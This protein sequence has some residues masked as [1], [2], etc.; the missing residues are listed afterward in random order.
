M[1]CGL[2]ASTSYMYLQAYP[3]VC[4]ALSYVLCRVEDPKLILPC[5]YVESSIVLSDVL[6]KLIA[7]SGTVFGTC[8][9]Y[10]LAFQKL[11]DLP[12]KCRGHYLANVEGIYLAS[13]CWV[14]P[15]IWR[16]SCLAYVDGLALQVWRVPPFLMF[17]IL[18]CEWWRSNLA[19]VENP[20]FAS[21]MTLRWKSW[22][23]NLADVEGPTLQM[24]R[25]PILQA[26]AERIPCTWGS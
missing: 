17:R 9:C 19:S 4:W 24:L 14:L 6:H 7:L 8:K 23:I 15:D 13:K 11:R 5:T 18:P 1:L 20:V 26:S 3:S 22:G 21:A 12:C 10:D 25:G 16:G 2:R